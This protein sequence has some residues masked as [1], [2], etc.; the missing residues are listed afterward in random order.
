[1]KTLKGLEGLEALEELQDGTHTINLRKWQK[2][3]RIQDQISKMMVAD[4]TK[5]LNLKQQNLRNLKFLNK[6][7]QGNHEL[8]IL[9]L[10]GSHMGNSS[11]VELSRLIESTN[12]IE[13]LNLSQNRIGTQGLQ[14]IC[15]ALTVN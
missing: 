12:T 7:L 1:M 2:N 5:T 14:H 11:C 6:S 15:S 10:T 4:S 3:H 9:D 8:R 13:V